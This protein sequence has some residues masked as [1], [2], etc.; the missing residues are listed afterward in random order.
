VVINQMTGKPP[1]YRRRPLGE[2][3]KDLAC[4]V[5]VLLALPF[6]L[7]REA[8]RTLFNWRKSGAP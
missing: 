5:L 4:L 6:V 7:A 3:L 1:L 8:A 2:F